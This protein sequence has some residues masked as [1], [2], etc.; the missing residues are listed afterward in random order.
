MAT[1]PRIPAIEVNQLSGIDATAAARLKNA[2]QNT[3][4][5]FERLEGLVNTLQ[6]Q[7]SQQG[8]AA[9]LS[10]LQAQFARLNALV[11]QLAAT[12]ASMTGVELELDLAGPQAL[13]ELAEMGKALADLSMVPTAGPQAL[14]ELAELTKRVEALEQGAIQ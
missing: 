9:T 5:R 7:A 8:Q 14:A 10:S 11:N 13:A 1:V 6:T 3:R 2:F 12:V 4:E